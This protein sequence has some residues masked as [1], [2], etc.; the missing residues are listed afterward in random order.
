MIIL[1]SPF[2]HSNQIFSRN[3]K[4]F[5][6]SHLTHCP[7]R[8][9]LLS[10]FVFLRCSHFFSFALS[11]SRPPYRDFSFGKN[12]DESNSLGVSVAHASTTGCPNEQWPLFECPALTPARA[13]ERCCRRWTVVIY[14]SARREK[15]F[16]IEQ[17]TPETAT[18]GCAP[19]GGRWREIFGTST[20]SLT[21]FRVMYLPFFIEM[22]HIHLYNES[23]RFTR[24]YTFSLEPLSSLST[25][26][27]RPLSD[28]GPLRHLP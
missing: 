24:V 1:L 9:S 11:P 13:L 21:Y 22:P 18:N 5:V 28:F 7:T 23:I 19:S 17:I 25:F 6:H 4:F 26:V 15:S 27:F 12:F 10:H 8:S 2:P 14:P 20:L 16:I 3:N